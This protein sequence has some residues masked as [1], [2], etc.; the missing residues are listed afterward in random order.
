MIYFKK[1]IFYAIVLNILLLGSLFGQINN[2]II[3]K[4]GNSIVTSLQLK[5]EINTILILTKREINQKNINDV[6]NFAT[7][8][9]IRN[10][11]KKNEIEKF[12]V[13]DYNKEELNKIISNISESL[14]TNKSGLKLIFMK[15]GLNYDAL[16]DKYKTDL[17]WNTLIFKKFKNQININIIEI[18]NDIKKIINKDDKKKIDI[19]KLRKKIINQ[20]KNEKLELFSRSHYSNLENNTLISE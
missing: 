10:I 20:Q 8:S 16:V 4:V 14:K 15:N 3:L 1:I 13:N 6:K 7:K 18:D 5:N 12:E 17:L 2:S 11:I 9:I 19:E